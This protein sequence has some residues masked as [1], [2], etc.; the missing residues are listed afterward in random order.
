MKKIIKKFSTFNQ[1]EVDKFGKINDWWD[2]NG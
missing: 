1:K 2:I